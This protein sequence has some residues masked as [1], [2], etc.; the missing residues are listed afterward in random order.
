MADHDKTRVQE[1]SDRIINW[2]LEHSAQFENEGIEESTLAGA[3]GL[4][5]EE[6]TAALDH[7]ENHEDLARI[8]EAL[9]D[10]PRF[11]LKPA[12]GWHD[13]VTRQERAN[14]ATE[15]I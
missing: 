7:L 10:P 11:L 3:I 8:P 14:P 13:I 4:S 1:N 5:E 12:R 6:V 15:S 9:S 2:L